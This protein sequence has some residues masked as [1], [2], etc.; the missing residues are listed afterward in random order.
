MTISRKNNRLERARHAHYGRIRRMRRL[1]KK[2]NLNSFFGAF[3]P[4]YIH[5]YPFTQ[6]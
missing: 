2:M 3:A 1:L 5:Y 6:P 4:R